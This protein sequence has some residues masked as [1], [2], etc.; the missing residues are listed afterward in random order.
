[1][2][3]AGEDPGDETVPRP[4]QESPE[5]G[6][7]PSPHDRSEASQPTSA[8]ATPAHGASAL[9]DSAW[10]AVADGSSGAA[11]AVRAAV[12]GVRGI[13]EAVV[14]GLAFLV[15]YT[16]WHS[17]PWAL[18]FSIAAALVFTAARVV[19]RSSPL[20][21]I[22]GLVGAVVSAALALITGKGQDNF[23][24]G[25]L[26]NAVFCLAMLVTVLARRPL[27]GIVAG[28]LTEQ[29]DWRSDRTRYRAMQ[30]VTLAWAAMFALRLVVEIPLY[31]AGNI[32]ALAIARLVTG[33]PL[34]APVFLL[35]WLIVRGVFRKDRP[36]GDDRIVST[37]R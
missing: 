18:A 25:M 13:V 15:V 14:P 23:L 34:Y 27:I 24:P 17:V 29:P 21:A 8:R 22:V 19:R 7:A 33:L 11:A 6:R 31:T 32:E 2:T 10:G 26:I 1:M 3:A 30:M 35:S 5:V 12:G 20:Q 16:I 37:S 4:A 36:G 9:Q 28:T